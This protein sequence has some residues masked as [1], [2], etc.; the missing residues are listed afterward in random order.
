MRRSLVKEE[1]RKLESNSLSEGEIGKKLNTR[2]ILLIGKTG[3]GKSTLANVLVNK[4]NNFEEVF[5]ESEFAVS[6]TKE[7]QIE[8]F[9]EDGIKY[10]IVDTIGI[11][12]TQLTTHEVLEKIADT[13][14]LIGDNLNQIIFVTSGRFTEREIEI[15]NMLREIMFDKKIVNYTTIVRTK[16][17]AF[18]KSEKC[19][20]DKEKL[21][22]ENKSVFEI[23]NSSR[24]LIH[25][26][27]MSKEE[28]PNLKSRIDS[29]LILLT[30]LRNCRDDYKITNFDALNE[31]VSNFM[32]EEERIEK[33][34]EETDRK[35]KRQQ[36]ENEKKLREAEEEKK[37]RL[38]EIEERKR[39]EKRE[40]EEVRQRELREL[41]ERQEKERREEQQREEQR[42]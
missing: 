35:L 9:E 1:K 20:D 24:K 27:N 17:P 36:E 33:E 16:F 23:I 26:N 3:N 10:Q 8:C 29:R 13:I 32:T 40:I 22:R 25:V 5:K 41:Q 2:N 21:L 14:Y 28:E 34:R 37:R 4:N 6:E 19:K 11:G 15:F 38:Q 12:D 18:R 31:R 30:H 7:T 39:K 42:R